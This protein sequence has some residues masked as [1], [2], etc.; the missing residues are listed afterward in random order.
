VPHYYLPLPN[1][2]EAFKSS[3]SRNMKEA[4]RKCYNS[5]KRAGHE[6]TFQVVSQPDHVPVALETFFDLH[7]E[8]SVAPNLPCHPNV[9]ARPIAREFLREYCQRM[10]ERDQLRIFQLVVGNEVIATRVGFVLG[11]DLYLYY[12]GY[13][14][15]W[16]QHSVM[17][18]LVAEAIQWAI[19]HGMAGLDL[20]TGRD[21]SKLRWKPTEIVACEGV[22]STPRKLR[23]LAAGAYRQMAVH[24]NGNSM[25]GRLL[26]PARRVRF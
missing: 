19:G 1:E 24:A 18:T 16:A 2:W 7:A 13:R 6:F 21:L 3:L 4:L 22:Q 12:S 14:S 8:R 9:F 26:S 20:S 15:A 25:L 5:L 10:A 23:Q 17:T 11:R